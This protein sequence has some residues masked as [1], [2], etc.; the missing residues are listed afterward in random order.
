MY[1]KFV[2]KGDS[3]MKRLVVDM[4]ESLHTAIK[5]EALK[6]RTSAKKLV[7]EMIEK[8]LETKKEQTH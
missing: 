7:T 1:K 3:N 5:I 2:Q 4:D 8:Y 6:Q